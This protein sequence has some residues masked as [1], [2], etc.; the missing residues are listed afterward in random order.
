MNVRSVCYFAAALVFA[1]AVLAFAFVPS[2]NASIVGSTY[3]F[4]TSESGDTVITPLG[5]PTVHT[6][7]TNPSFCV[8]SISTPPDCAGGHGLSGSFAFANVSSTMDTITFSF[9]GTTLGAGPGAFDIDL[10]HFT[11]LDGEVVKA[12]SYAGGF[13]FG[14]EFP[15]KVTFNGA[16]AVFTQ[17]AGNDF[18]AITGT[19]VVFDVT[20]TRSLGGTSTVPEPATLFLIAMGLLSTGVARRHW[21]LK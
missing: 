20:T 11:T 18:D 6:D 19:S 14:A 15:P 2:A 21:R 16:D 9:I 8:G 17:S 7:P 4:T 1:S 12:V 5:G 3:D 13:I 10:G